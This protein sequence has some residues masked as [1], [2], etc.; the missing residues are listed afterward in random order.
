MNHLWHFF[1]SNDFW[2]FLNFKYFNF[3]SIKFSFFALFCYI[4][5]SMCFIHFVDFL[6]CRLLHNW[7]EQPKWLKKL[8]NY[9]IFNIHFFFQKAPLQFFPN[10]RVPSKQ[11]Y[12]RIF[13]I[14]H[15]C[16]NLYSSYT[17]SFWNFLRK[18]V[19]ENLK[20]SI[21]YLEF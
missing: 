16:K 7:S 6:I 2:G 5:K 9:Q 21:L 20:E 11:S 14:N 10:Y 15:F 17:T 1:L 3:Y 13:R 8:R 12:I 19:W 4:L 18:Y